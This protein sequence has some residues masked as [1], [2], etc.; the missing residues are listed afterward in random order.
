MTDYFE[1]AFKEVIA[2]E[3]GYSDDPNDSGGKTKYGI[4]QKA[5]PTLDIASLTLDDAKAIYKRD[6]WDKVKGDLLPY[7]LNIFVFDSAV[8]QGVA[9]AIKLLQRTASVPQDGV[10][11]TATLSAVN[12]GK[13]TA[14]DYMSHRAVAYTG[15][16]GADIYLRGWLK[17]LFVLARLGRLP[18]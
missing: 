17:R 2:A 8:N 15:T 4:S 16:R 3:G 14:A 10:L 9:T 12:A 1:I 11:G 5:Y 18:A 7:P 6:Y 13:V